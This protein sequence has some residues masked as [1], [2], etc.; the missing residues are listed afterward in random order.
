MIQWF[1][2]QARDNCTSARNLSLVL[3]TE[4]PVLTTHLSLAFPSAVRVLATTSAGE[5]LGRFCPTMTAHP[6]RGLDAALILAP[7]VRRE[8]QSLV[9]GFKSCCSGGLCRRHWP[10]EQDA[11]V[12]L[13]GGTRAHPACHDQDVMSLCLV[14]ACRSS[15]IYLKHCKMYKEQHAIAGHCS[16]LTTSDKGQTTHL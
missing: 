9:E 6:L 5:K 1:S 8:I 4:C 7:D 2:H 16:L 13:R 14:C 12:G 11:E 10:L 3:I 15:R